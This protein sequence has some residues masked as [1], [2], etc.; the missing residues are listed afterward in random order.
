M[1]KIL[2]IEENVSI[3]AQFQI[4]QRTVAIQEEEWTSWKVSPNSFLNV[5][6]VDIHTVKNTDCQNNTN[7]LDYHRILKK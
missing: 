6:G 4:A 1:V 3:A 7:V 5:I 2:R